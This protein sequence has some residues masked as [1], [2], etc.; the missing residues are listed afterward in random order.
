PDILNGDTEKQIQAVADYI[1]VYREPP[2]AS[3]PPKAPPPAAK[4]AKQVSAK[5]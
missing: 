2:P 3:P 5:P 4:S 1:R